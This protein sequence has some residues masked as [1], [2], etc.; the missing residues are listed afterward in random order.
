MKRVYT[1]LIFV[2]VF[3]YFSDAQ[4]KFLVFYR[5]TV[6]EQGDYSLTV[7]DTYVRGPFL[8]STVWVHNPTSRFLVLDYHYAYAMS[9]EGVARKFKNNEN[10]VFL[11]NGDY[12]QRL[13][14]KAPA[15]TK[16]VSI[17]FPKVLVSDKVILAYP[18]LDVP[19]EEGVIRKLGDLSVQV[20]KIITYDKEFKIRIRVRYEG[21]EFLAINFA[22]ISAERE[23]SGK[24]YNKIRS[25][26]RMHHR[27]SKYLEMATLTF[28]RREGEKLLKVIHF[29]DVFTTY[30]LSPMQNFD[31]HYSVQFDESASDMTDEELRE[32]ER[33]EEE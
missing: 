5:D 33:K 31:L 7:K 3:V 4:N 20:L 8:R 24:I 10:A 26:H 12:K 14:F 1:V 30:T 6:T 25:Y 2:L 16:F 19:K 15:R 11:P 21:E 9:E 17:H 13:R 22:N 29:E 28:P 27:K 18:T 32:K 23:K